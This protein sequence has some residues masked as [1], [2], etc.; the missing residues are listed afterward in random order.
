MS[1]TIRF[2]REKKWLKETIRNL[3]ETNKYI[4]GL[5]P[6]VI[7]QTGGRVIHEVAGTFPETP[8]LI[9]FYICTSHSSLGEHRH[10]YPL[11]LQY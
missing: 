5:E 1:H 7:P 9:I 11:M 4:L 6:D 8:T 3:K 10:Q 2:V